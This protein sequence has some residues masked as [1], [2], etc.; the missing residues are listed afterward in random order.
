M[1]IPLIGRAIELAGGVAEIELVGGER[2]RAD[3]ALHPDLSIDQYVLVDRGL[4]IEVVEADEAE[5]IVAFY[6]E[7]ENLWAE[8]DVLHG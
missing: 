4:V 1:C 8:E 3:V 6:A 2:I 5:R 7:L